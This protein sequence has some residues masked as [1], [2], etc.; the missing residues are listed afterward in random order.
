MASVRGRI[1][2]HI[3]FIFAGAM[4][5][6]ASSITTT[7]SRPIPSTTSVRGQSIWESQQLRESLKE[8]VS[9]HPNDFIRFETQASA[10]LF[11]EEHEDAYRETERRVVLRGIMG[12]WRG[13]TLVVLPTLPV[14]Q[15]F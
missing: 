9:G 10:A 12:Y 8:D 6:R 4:S 14:G 13:K 2:L 11:I 7:A 15:N 5:T 1:A 3:A